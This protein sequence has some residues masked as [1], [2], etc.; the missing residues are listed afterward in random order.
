MSAYC[1]VQTTAQMGSFALVSERT[2]PTLAVKQWK[3]H[4]LLLTDDAFAH[5]G[6]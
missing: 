6:S 4:S 3:S 1:V 2:K 5:P